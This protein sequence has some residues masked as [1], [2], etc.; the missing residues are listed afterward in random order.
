MNPK[1]KILDQNTNQ[2]TALTKSACE[3]YF[4][5][6]CS[7]NNIQKMIDIIN[8]NSNVS[9]RI[10]DMFVTYLN[11]KNMHMHISRDYENNLSVYSKSLFDPFKRVNIINCEYTY[12]DDITYFRSSVGQ[13]NFFKWLFENDYLDIVENDLDNIISFM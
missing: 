7:D 4:A 8:G 2:F 13:L 11:S 9:L 6:I 5:N 10:I 1:F 12:N 3:T